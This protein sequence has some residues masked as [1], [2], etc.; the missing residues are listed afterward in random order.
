MI[1]FA[2]FVLGVAG[3]ILGLVGM[4]DAGRPTGWGVVAAGFGLAG[5]GLVAVRRLW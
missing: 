1:R 4:V 5:L 2:S 3:V